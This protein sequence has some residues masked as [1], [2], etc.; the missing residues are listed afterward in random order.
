MRGLI[1]LVLAAYLVTRLLRALPVLARWTAEGRRPLACNVCMSVWG[2]LLALL[3]RELQPLALEW[4]AVAGGALWALELAET[5]R[6]PPLPPPLA[7]GPGN[8]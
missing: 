6:P 5:L 3:L 1:F 7:R 8:V 4:A 2:A